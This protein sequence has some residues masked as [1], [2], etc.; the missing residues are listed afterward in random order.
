M[1]V[2]ELGLL[3][4][5]WTPLEHG[6]SHSL[7]SLL[8]APVSSPVNLVLSGVATFCSFLGCGIFPLIPSLFHVLLVGGLYEPLPVALFRATI[9]SP[10]MPYRH[11]YDECA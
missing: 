11:A 1:M 9:V 8:S 10:T 7:L 3:E 6:A 5:V 4:P 2:Q